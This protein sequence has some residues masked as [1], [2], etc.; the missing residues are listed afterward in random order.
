M[1]LLRS[2]NLCGPD[3]KRFL[4]PQA[5]TP[6]KPADGRQTQAQ[7]LLTTSPVMSHIRKSD[8]F[9]LIE[10]VIVL[11]I[12]GVTAAVAVPRFVRYQRLEETRSGAQVIANA[13]RTARERA[14]REGIQWFV[15]FNPAVPPLP[16]GRPV[17]ALVIQ[18]SD[19]SFTQ[20]VGDTTRTI[21]FGLGTDPSVTPYGLVAA[22]PWPAAALA[23]GDP[24]AGPLGGVA[25]GST[26]PVDATTGLRGVGFTSRGIPVQLAATPVP[27]A[28][29]WGSGSGAFYVTDNAGGVFAAVL[30]PLGEVRVRGLE[31][32]SGTWR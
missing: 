29:P 21:P 7:R 26:F 25:T 30:Q 11:A 32:A 13:L 17:V 27:G 6:R 10:L 8:G 12:I 18:D 2:G 5:R 31:G 1:Q 20:S 14:L 19:N 3:R 4:D 9:S 28:G 23:P 24:A 15:L 16:D 22:P